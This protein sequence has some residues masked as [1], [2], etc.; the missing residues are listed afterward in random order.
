M[1]RELL[2]KY[3]GVFVYLLKNEVDIM[4]ELTD[5][6]VILRIEEHMLHL[7]CFCSSH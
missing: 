2:L 6:P 5:R 1:K 4:C 7:P 3:I